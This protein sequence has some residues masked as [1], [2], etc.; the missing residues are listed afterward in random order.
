MEEMLPY[1]KPG[2]IYLCEDIHGTENQFAAYVQGFS[3]RINEM[4]CKEMPNGVSGLA[5][6]LSNFQK[7]IYAIHLYPFC[8]VI[9]KRDEALSQ[10]KAP[11]HGN[12]WQ[13]FI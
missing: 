7:A 4:E 13:P 9:E 3:K 1:L 12:K 11:K 8:L 5:S 10:F 2:G 6:D